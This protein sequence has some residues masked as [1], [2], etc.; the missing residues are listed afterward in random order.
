MR[1]WLASLARVNRPGP[2]GQIRIAGQAIYVLPTKYGLMYLVLV[3]ALLIGAINY[4]NNPAFLLTFLLAGAGLATLLQ[5]WRNLHGL[6]LRPVAHEPAF[7]GEQVLFRF[8]LVEPRGSER[9]GLQFELG[10]HAAVLHDLA[11]AGQAFVVLPQPASQRGRCRAERVVVSSRYPLGLVKAWCYVD[12]DAWAPVYPR[13]AEAAAAPPAQGGGSAAGEG[14][15]PGAEDFVGLRD[16]RPGDPIRRLDWKA[17]AGERGVLT[18]QFGDGG[19]ERLWLDW[20]DWPFLPEEAR[21]SRLCR[22]VLTAHRAGCR[23]GLRL[24]ERQIEPALGEAHRRACL[25][26]LALHGASP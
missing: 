2:D 1:A 6:L 18:K 9:P 11:A 24:P 4:A 3:L 25:T 16:Y 21:L 19:A 8:R 15:R 7:A 23:Y 14:R 17:L 13:P 20:A 22:E 5:T 12:A 10:T 26:A